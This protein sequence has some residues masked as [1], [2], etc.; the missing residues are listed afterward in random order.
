MLLAAGAST[1]E[2]QFVR[3]LLVREANA[4]RAE[5][6][7]YIQ[8][9]DAG[10]KRD[11]LPAA[12][13]L[14]HFPDFMDRPNAPKQ[15]PV[16]KYYNLRQ[17]DVVVAFDLD[18]SRLTTKQ[19]ELLE[20]WVETRG[21]GLVVI[22]GPIHTFKLAQPAA[23]RKLKP[24]LDLLPI[25][26]GDNRRQDRPADKPW[27]LSF[28]GAKPD[29]A[30]LKLDRAS[31]SHLAGWGEFFTGRAKEDLKAEVK[32]GMYGLY[33]V[34]KVKK[35]ATVIAAFGD[36]KARM[37]DGGD[38]PYLVAIS[39]GNGKVFWIGSGETWR[40]RQYKE[41]YHERFWVELVKYV[42]ATALK[43]LKS[44]KK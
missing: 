36:P 11:D 26:P 43:P 19:L 2:F 18:W 16:K 30:F 9:P 13:Q 29:M 22:G 31:K 40:L 24:I 10:G 35:T 5:V 33:P 8:S 39:H 12:R 17:Y 44:N 28:S 37:D 14:T 15:D 34:T 42:G 21:G 6:S 32:R 23:G 20:K 41:A 4:Q 25:V 3:A 1:R 38:H 27:R 7:T